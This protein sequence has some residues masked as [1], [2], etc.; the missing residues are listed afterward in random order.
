MARFTFVTWDGGGNVPPA[1]GIAQ[2]LAARG[3]QVS[4]I[5]Y[6]VQRERIAAS[7]FAFGAL[8]RSGAFDIY[9]APPGPQRITDTI[10]NVWASADHLADI[11]AALAADPA[12]VL[13]VDFT[14][15]GALAAASRI[16]IPV[17][18][19]AHSTIAGLV[20]PPSVPIGAAR[21]SATN[22]LRARAGLPLLGRL[23]EGWEG[24][25]TLVTTIAEL[26]PCAA[27]APDTHRYVGPVF[28]N[29]PD[30][31]WRS[32][33][34]PDDP[35]PLV[36]VS[37]TTTRFWDQSG[38]IRNTV[39]A[40]GDLGVRVLVS[41]T[42]PGGLAL[43]PNT[44]IRQYVPH[45]R[46][47]ALTSVTV[48]HCGHGTVA[49]SLAHGVPMVGLPNPAADQPFLA[50]K[51]QELGA[52]LALDGEAPPEVIRAAVCRVLA[53]GSFRDAAGRLRKAIHA[54]P[55]ARGAAAALEHLTHT[56]SAIAG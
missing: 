17:A 2:V 8:G 39:E 51:V 33:W 54:T 16:A 42:C 32:P 3:H 38:R 28:E 45:A 7:G 36:L 31:A 35:R 49:A 40:L 11:P 48:T 4:F 53:E 6:E 56:P 29:V 44:E 12:D 18:A 27:G 30:A 37:F 5:G 41:G 23:H 50:Q 46:V 22:D 21:L 9:A 26:D 15:H 19:L 43:P 52:G 10:R 14:M 13:V 47:L 34:A 1:I 20:A 24:F 55:G 25:L